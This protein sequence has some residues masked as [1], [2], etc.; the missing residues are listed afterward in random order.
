MQT[1]GVGFEDLLPCP[2]RVVTLD[3]NYMSET[4]SGE[5]LNAEV[6][7]ALGLPPWSREDEQPAS[8]PDGDGK[9]SR[10]RGLA[11]SAGSADGVGV[12]VREEGQALVGEKRGER[13]GPF[14]LSV[15]CTIVADV[16]HLIKPTYPVDKRLVD[17]LLWN[18]TVSWVGLKK[19]WTDG[20]RMRA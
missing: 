13:R 7:A 18:V 17:A 2:H 5:I 16:N 3:D 14:D 1:P 20:A 15:I 4:P 6:S 11:G 9:R 12:E 19:G 10:I 8:N